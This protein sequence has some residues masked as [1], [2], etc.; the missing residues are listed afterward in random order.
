M[1]EKKTVSVT[2]TTIM[3][4]PV[5]PNLSVNAGSLQMKAVDKTKKAIDKIDHKVVLTLLSVLSQQCS[6]IFQP[7]ICVPKRIQA[8]DP[9]TRNHRARND[10]K[11]L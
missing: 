10:A 9:R 6:A 5:V 11:G 4:S 1:I 3:K 2:V 8:W 7:T